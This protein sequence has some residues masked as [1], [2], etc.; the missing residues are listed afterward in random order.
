MI[1]YIY[2]RPI[3]KMSSNDCPTSE[4]EARAIARK[5]CEQHLG[6]NGNHF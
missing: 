1:F 6:L 2:E 5:M 3:L 4:Q